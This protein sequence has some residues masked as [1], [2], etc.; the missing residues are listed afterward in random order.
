MIGHLLPLVDIST[1]LT[2]GIAVTAVVLR[3]TQ[4]KSQIIVTSLCC[5]WKLDAAS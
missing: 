5:P 3:N 1:I 4:V 2:V